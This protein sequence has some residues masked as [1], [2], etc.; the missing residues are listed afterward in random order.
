MTF[1]TKRLGVSLLVLTLVATGCS[2]P[3]QVDSTA[4]E[5]SQTEPVQP[6]PTHPEAGAPGNGP[7]SIQPPGAPTVAP[8]FPYSG[9]GETLAL[10]QYVDEG[11]HRI[12]FLDPLGLGMRE[13][14]LP[15][16]AQLPPF[17]E[18]G[19]SPDG[20][21]YAYYT[22]STDTGDLTLVVYDLNAESVTTEIPLLSSDFPDNF[23]ELA[24]SFI[25]S[26]NI[27]QELDW[28]EPE[29]MARELQFAFE[30][31]IKTF[32]WSPDGS[33][34]AFSGQ[35]E[36]PSSDLY[37]LDLDSQQITRLTSG[38][39]MME[40]IGWSPDG[41]WIRHNSTYF[42]GAGYRVTNHVASRD[43][44]QV[45][46]FPFNT[47]R[48]WGPWLTNNLYLANDGANGPGSY[49]LMVMDARTGT[50]TT[51]FYEAFGSYALNPFSDTIVVQCFP[52][53][54]PNRERAVYQIEASEPYEESLFSDQSFSV[55]YIGHGE[56]QY[57]GL[58]D[59][60]GTALI[61]S[62][63]SLER[64]ADVYL[65]QVT[66]RTAD[67]LALTHTG[68]YDGDPE[69]WIYNTN[70][71]QRTDVFS[72][73]VS[74]VEWRPDSGAIF[75]IAGHDLRT[76]NLATGEHMLLQN[77]PGS[78]VSRSVFTWVNLP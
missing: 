50:A 38:T 43:G 22:G 6:E 61:R 75:Y 51:I 78:P 39:G 44:S 65:R 40:R 59:D 71:G 52:F 42:V 29:N 13:F 48:E 14:R 28:V 3:D 63:G 35:M 74:F 36:G 53:F 21:Y 11:N 37:L 45:I 41:Y 1:Q 20:A 17:M 10:I 8:E 54:D 12:V 76:Y 62:D 18:T 46:S 32:A 64:I 60:R 27:P 66:A 4:T 19:L 49:N 25:N 69:L 34:L 23:Q 77:W 55:S 70:L 7:D 15:E 9:R 72:G 26:G 5:A 16:G 31:G 2:L 47:G 56:Y 68:S 30:Y 24:D 73:Y 67:L 33:Y 58:T 57:F